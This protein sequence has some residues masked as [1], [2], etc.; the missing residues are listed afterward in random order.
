MGHVYR[1]T[2]MRLN[3]TVAIKVLPRAVAREARAARDCQ[4][5]ATL[6][7]LFHASQ[8]FQDFLVEFRYPHVRHVQAHHDL[9][10]LAESPTGRRARTPSSV[11][12]VT[13]SVRWTR[14]RSRW[15]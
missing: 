3:R 12:M 11:A 10:C 4:R 5:A 13:S 2:D 9:R 14:I 6:C 8:E 1:A 7:E 15:S